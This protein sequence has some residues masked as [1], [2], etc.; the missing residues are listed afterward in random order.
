MIE[1]KNISKSFGNNTVLTDLS[2]RVNPGEALTVIGGSGSGKSVLFKHIIGL[3]K[4]DSGSVF[5]N[6]VDITRLKRK[7][8]FGIIGQFAMVF[9]GGALFDSLSV[10]ENVAFGIEEKD[11]KGAEELE[12]IVTRSLESVGMPGIAHL[13]P[14]E[15]SG[16]MRKRVAIARAIA[17]E[18]KIIMYD[19]PTTGLD[20]IMADVINRLII[21]FG[22][23]PDITTIVI[24]HDMVSAYKISDRIAMLYDGRIIETGT[25]DQIRNTK[26][27]LVS[28][29][30]EGR[31]EPPQSR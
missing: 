15:L 14:S 12:G 5:L 18:P 7:A 26:N 21:K 28:Q 25:P 24:T 3:M 4:P 16:G 23:S 31:S 22:A 9:Q 20:P 13:M 6:D 19:E 27:P 30:I 11:K 8:L 1:I 10:G 17:R 29:F 2:L